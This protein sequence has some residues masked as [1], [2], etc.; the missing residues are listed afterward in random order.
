MKTINSAFKA[1]SKNELSKIVGGQEEVTPCATPATSGPI[2]MPS[3]TA[4]VSGGS[5]SSGG[6][7][8]IPMSQGD[9]PGVAGGITSGVLGNKPCLA[10]S[11][12]SF[13][14]AMLP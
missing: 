2:P 6:G 13:N 12:I 14:V 4:M 11:K 3:P 9:Q 5:G 1:L 7:S 8:S 10:S